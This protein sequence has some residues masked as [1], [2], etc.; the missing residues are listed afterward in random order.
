M[1]KTALILAGGLG[2]RLKDVVSDMPKCLAPVA[3]KP[4]LDYLIQYYS[5]QGIE[6]FIFSLGY[7]HEE[8]LLFLGK[9]PQL[10]Y[11]YVIEKEPLGTGG[12]IKLALE[13]LTDKEESILILNGDSF[14]G[15][16]LKYFSA[17]HFRHNAELSIALK[18]MQNIS[19][20]GVVELEEG[21]RI[22]E[23]KEKQYYSSGLINGGCYILKPDEFL[24]HPWPEKFSF[25]K[26]FL[27]KD[28][29]EKK[30]YGYIENSYFI[31]IGI[32][33]DYYKAQIELPGHIDF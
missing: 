26:E 31:D 28:G 10:R 11:S 5:R 7:K 14:F 27:E 17:F 25:E 30:I 22:S 16:N 19:R 4:F 21:N 23:F 33:D 1:I 6:N 3:G 15:I 18:Y 2:T 24:K 12:G 13:S 8:I 32:P 29:I 9:Y 20:Y